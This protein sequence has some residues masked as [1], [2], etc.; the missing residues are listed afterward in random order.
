MKVEPQSYF[1]L[2]ESVF[3]RMLADQSLTD[4]LRF[5]VGDYKHV[6]LT[7]GG[8]ASFVAGYRALERFGNDSVRFWFFDTLIEDEDLYGFL[9]D[10]E[11][12]L[13]IHIERFAEGRN[14][15]EVFRDKRFIGNS[16]VDVCSRLIKR[17]FL[18]ELLSQQYPDKD[19]TLHFG[20]EWTESH[21]IDTVRRAWKEKGYQT[22]FPLTWSPL[23][24]PE[25]Y[26]K[27]VVHLGVRVP[28]LYSLGFAHNNCGGACVKAGIGQWARLWAHFPDRYAWH[29][30]WEQAIRRQLRKNVAILRNRI[31]GRTRPMTLRFLRWRLQ[32][33][34][35]ELV[36]LA[37]VVDALP[38][39][40][41]CSCFV[42]NTILF[43]DS[44]EEP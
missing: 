24:V 38:D 16:R 22:E 39:D 1:V 27:L 29:E 32:Q 34:R 44:P 30:A 18:E 41:A 8:L 7:S 15:W 10:S 40:S 43:Q 5:D 21:R 36:N 42:P 23:L 26:R 3:D 14:P 19:V 25:D 35:G 31:G 9:A 6:V 33:T 11:R 20:L 2:N 28:R 4:Q 13:G 17:E 12:A 37:D